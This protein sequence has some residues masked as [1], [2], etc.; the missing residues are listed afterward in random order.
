MATVTPGYYTFGHANC[1]EGFKPGIPVR[2]REGSIVRF[3]GRL[4]KADPEPGMHEGRRVYALAA[5]WFDAAANAEV[6]DVEI[7]LDARSD[8]AWASLVDLAEYPPC[9][10]DRQAG[11]STFPFFG[12]TVSGTL[13]AELTK[14][15][16]SEGGFSDI[17]PDTSTGGVLTFEG[18]GTRQ[19]DVTTDATF[20]QTMRAGGLVVTMGDEVIVNRIEATFFKRVP[21][22]VA[23]DVLYLQEAR[24][25][26]GPRETLTFEG[27][28]QD[29]A[30]TRSAVG[31]MDFQPFV[32]GE[33]T[34]TAHEDGSGGDR[35]SG[36]SVVKQFGGGGF[37]IHF[38]NGDDQVAWASFQIRGRKLLT[39]RPQTTRFDDSGSIRA[40]GAQPLLPV[41]FDYVESAATART[42]SEIIL[43]IFSRPTKT[44]REVGFVVK[45]GTALATTVADLSMGDLIAV[46]EP[47]AAVTVTQ[48]IWI[49]SERRTY[50]PNG[51]T[52]VVF[53]CFPSFANL[54]DDFAIWDETNWD[55]SG[56]GF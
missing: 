39:D 50:H 3:R 9:A 8:R 25:Y 52:D 38:T 7:L 37:T 30:Q 4:K 45:D 1:R 19:I 16:R 31:G 48:R 34:A 32:A 36:L 55:E 26:I 20:D 44:T 12:D 51:I 29:A 54:G 23:T 35:T 2:V 14:V 27:H 33:Y 13:L 5:D 10:V 41:T 28:Y 11:S 46:G 18:R 53:G 56:W 15:M 21:S 17:R 49:Q 24:Q 43:N 40:H 47:L 22:D 6:H 42:L